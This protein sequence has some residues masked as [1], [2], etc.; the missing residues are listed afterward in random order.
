MHAS[1]YIHNKHDKYNHL[2]KSDVSFSFRLSIFNPDKLIQYDR[3]IT[4]IVK[5]WFYWI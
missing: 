1:Y 2:K 4:I 5:H 3:C